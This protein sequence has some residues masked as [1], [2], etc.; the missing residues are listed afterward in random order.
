MSTSKKILIALFVGMFIPPVSIIS[1]NLLIMYGFWYFA[2][3]GMRT[4]IRNYKHERLLRAEQKRRKTNQ[5]EHTIDGGVIYPEN[6]YRSG[7]NIRCRYP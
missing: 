6:F 4:K 3:L 7:S 1:A 2:V 5:E